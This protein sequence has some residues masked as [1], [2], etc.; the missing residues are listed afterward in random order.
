M[1]EISLMMMAVTQLALLNNAGNVMV[2]H[3]LLAG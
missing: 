3:L 1:M 2:F